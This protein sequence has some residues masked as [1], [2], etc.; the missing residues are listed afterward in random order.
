MELILNTLKAGC[1]EI[2][3]KDIK[4]ENLENMEVKEIDALIGLACKDHEQTIVLSGYEPMIHPDFKRIVEKLKKL[5]M[6]NPFKV[7]ILTNGTHLIDFAEELNELDCLIKI[8][9]QV[10]PISRIGENSY[11]NIELFLSA[12]SE[13]MR[14]IIWFKMILFLKETNYEYFWHLT[15]YIDCSRKKDLGESHDDISKIQLTIDSKR[16][17]FDSK[18]EFYKAIKPQYVKFLQEAYLKRL[19]IALRCNIVPLCYLEVGEIALLS[20]VGINIGEYI[21]CCQP[22]IC[23]GKG[24]SYTSCFHKLFNQEKNIF[25]YNKKEVEEWIL[26]SFNRAVELNYMEKCEG[27]LAKKNSICFAGCL[28]N[29]KLF[30]GDKDEKVF[31]FNN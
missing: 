13:K 29:S 27:C 20:R 6:F 16:I 24:C 18:D 28:K 5:S 25:T 2:C 9:I 31:N 11:S 23:F 15:D 19:R 22:L 8:I 1:D 14:E 21:T 4:P 30:E 26:G 3:F 12:M 17:G 10:E 7:L